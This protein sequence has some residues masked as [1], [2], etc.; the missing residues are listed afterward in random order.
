LHLTLS[1]VGVESK[2]P[3]FTVSVDEQGH[4]AYESRAIQEAKGTLT[5]GEVAQLKTLYDDVNWEQETLNNP[6]SADDRTLFKLEVDHGDGNKKLYQMSEAMNHRSW[7]F[8]DLIHFLRH[9][10][11]LNGE[12][13]ANIIEE[14]REQPPMV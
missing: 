3:L 14:P 9:N 11:A 2:V 12:P 10:V 5:Q 1:A 7:Q 13:L 8:R 4:W 6:V